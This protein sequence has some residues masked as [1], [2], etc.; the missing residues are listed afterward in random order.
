M[1]FTIPV[2]HRVKIKK[3]KKSEK[4]LDL[5]NELRKLGNMSL[6]VIPIVIGSLGTVPKGLERGREELEIGGQ[7]ENIQ[8]STFLTSAIIL[9]RVLETWEDLLSLTLQ[10][11]T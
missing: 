4:Y 11:R 5:A 2:D 10:W 1:D 3:R 9:G 7:I 8:T 6:T